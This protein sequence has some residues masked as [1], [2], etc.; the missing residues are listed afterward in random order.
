[1]NIEQMMG[2]V[3]NTR[4]NDYEYKYFID[5]NGDCR[6]YNKES[7]KIYENISCIFEVSNINIDNSD[8][9]LIKHGEYESLKEYYNKC[10]ELDKKAPEMFKHIMID[11]PIK[12]IKWLN[13]FINHSLS[14]FLSVCLTKNNIDLTALDLKENNENNLGV[15]F[16]NI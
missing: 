16:G 7:S 14:N 1:M 3:E 2:F 13:V 8:V 6:Y 11:I 5:D 15:Y 12:D 10:L 9:S 4:F